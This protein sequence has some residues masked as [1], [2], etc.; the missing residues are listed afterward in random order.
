MFARCPKSGVRYPSVVR[1]A[2]LV[3]AAAATLWI[4]T[5]QLPYARLNSVF[6]PGA[7][8]G[9]TNEI[10]VSGADLDGPGGPRFSDPRILATPT[11]SNALTFSV[12]IPAEMPP[13]LVDVRWVGRFGASN[14]RGFVVGER[15][16]LIAPSTNTTPA[17]AA[18]LPRETVMNG[19]TSA[20]Q[21]NWF[22]F[23]AAVGE[24]VQ[25]ELQTRELDSRLDPIV[26]V[27]D[28]NGRTLQTSRRGTLEFTAGQSGSYRLQVRDSTYRGGEDFVFRLMLTVAPHVDFALPNVLRAGE[29]NRVTLYGRNLPG[30]KPSPVTGPDGRTVDEIEAEIL[31]PPDAGAFLVEG[32]AKPASVFLAGGN[33]SWRWTNAVGV[34]NPIWF[35]TT[36]NTIWTSTTNGVMPVAPPGEFSGVFPRRGERSGVTFEAKKGEVLWLELSADRLGWPCDPSAI[37]QRERKTKGDAGETLYA[38]VLELSDSEANLGG[39]EFNTYTRDAAARFEAPEDGRYR[40]LVRDLF[41]TGPKSPQYPYRLSLRREAPD[42]ALVAV[43]VQPV[44]QNDNDRNIYPITPF[45]RQGETTPVKVVAFRRDGF[46]GEIE[47]SAT[48]LPVGI[49]AAATRIPPGQ[50][51]G[52]VLLTSAEAG[53]A[54]SAVPWKIVGRATT[55]A[56]EMTRMAPLATVTGLVPDFNEQA[57]VARLAR[58]PLLSVSAVEFAPVT[59]TPLEDKTWEIATNG[60][61]VLPVSI[62]RRSDFNAAFSLKPAGRVELDKL[63]PASIP[64]KATNATLEFELAEAKLPEGRGLWWLQGTIAGKYRNNPEALAEAETELKAAEQALAA[65]TDADKPALETR[66]KEAEERKKSAEERAKPRDVTWMIYSQPFFVKTVPA[67]PPLPPSPQ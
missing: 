34:S 4:A 26:S 11:G 32:M 9:T 57:V 53:A 60:K 12:V 18:E 21:A 40:V 19:R 14:P 3:V 52:F 46:G 2:C 61:L 8:A 13:G 5:A 6:P 45:L 44:K 33:L 63:K 36:T 49:T 48:N 30:A 16:E 51:T 42:F 67:S 62:V 17:A 54:T 58:E 37:V 7:Q 22:R 28:T 50:N 10:T 47:L 1:G 25:V 65:A 55:P 35:A 23:D 20:N 43:P 38:D 39:T 27:G 29:T 64:E 24:R 41:H 15:R 56:G 31:T 66:K 59:V